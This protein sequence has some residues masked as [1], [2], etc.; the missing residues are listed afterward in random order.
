[1]LEG[2]FGD[3]SG[4]PYL[5]ARISIPRLSLRGF[6][7]FLVDTGADGTVFM[8]ADSK[9]LGVNFGTLRNPVTSEGIG[10][11]AKG[12]NE[13]VVLSFSDR[14]FIYSYLLDIEIAA[15]TARNYRFPSLLGRDVID[16]WRFVMDRG[17]NK[18]IFTPRKWDLR[19]KI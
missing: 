5:E 9:K 4:A 14:R 2:R 10:G 6:V 12:F 18:V 11:A 19:Q 13:Q 16:Q 1:M 15:P 7:S 8:P 3:T 17:N